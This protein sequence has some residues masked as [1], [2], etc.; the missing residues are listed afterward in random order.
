[1]FAKSINKMLYATILC[2]LVLADLTASGESFDQRSR[3]NRNDK[4]RST[5]ENLL[6][7]LGLK[8][9]VT[10]EKIV[11]LL[12]V[13]EK[14]ILSIALIERRK[15][16]SA[17]PKLLEILRDT[18]TFDLVKEG[19]AEALCGF[20]NREW[21][22]T[23]KTLSMD[24]NS[25]LSQP[26]HNMDIAGL[27]AR[28]G[29][30]SQFE[31]VKKYAVNDNPRLR[32]F[33][34]L[35]LGKFGHK[36]NPVT[37]RAVDLLMQ[38]ATSDLEPWLRQMAIYSLDEIAQVKPDVKSKVIGACQANVNSADRSLSITAKSTL[39]RYGERPKKPKG[40]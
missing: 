40:N 3:V 32:H 18:K 5:E 27:L 20:G 10:D 21:I 14:R 16:T 28:A 25:I 29:D 36:T 4:R 15:I 19:A 34:I 13:P 2:F 8:K 17:T 9:D 11:Q 33:A 35:A 31:L 12:D 39:M 24:P 6:N 23:I 1:M 37:D 7:A 30:Y 26:P 22:T 38:A